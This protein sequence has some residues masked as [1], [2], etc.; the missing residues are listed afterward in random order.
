[1]ACSPTRANPVVAW[2]KVAPFQFVV[3]W[4][5]EQSC[6]K[7]AALWGG[8]LVP[9]KSPWWQ[10]QQAAL[11]RVKLLLTWHAAHCWLAWSPTRANPVVAWLKVAPL[12]FVVVCQPE[13][14][15]GKLADLC[16]GLLVPL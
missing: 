2:L 5:P 6:G 12:Q 4:Q 10:L 9:L 11:V 16:G 14:S 7:L 13:Q 1:V 15:C 8:L 3:V